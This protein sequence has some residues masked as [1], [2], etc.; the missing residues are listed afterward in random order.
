MK[1]VVTGANGF[2][3]SHVVRCLARAGHTVVPV[4][5]PDANTRFLNKRYGSPVS[6]AMNSL[7]DFRSVF[8]GADCVVHAAALAK[9]WGAWEEFNEANNL[10]AERVA[11]AAKQF[12]VRHLVHISTNA[13]LGEEDCS[14]A[15]AEDAPYNPRLPYFGEGIVRSA[16][17]FY[18]ETKTEGEKRVLA[19]AKEHQLDTTVVRPVW[20]FGPREFHSGPYEY[21][22][23]VRDLPVFPGC[24]S[25]LFHAVF[26][27][28]VARMV[29]VI[30]AKHPAGVRVYNCGAKRVLP[31]AEFFGMFSRAMGARPPMFIPKWSAYLF[32]TMIELTARVL[33]TQNPPP[34]TRARLYM[35]YAN[36]VYDVGK[37]ERELGFVADANYERAIRKTI[38][39]WKKNKFL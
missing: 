30:V 36:N 18:R 32:A 14:T 15:K 11:R 2:I 22:K 27:E 34:L 25:N 28:D 20:V 13:V 38:R 29:E 7:G 17:N 26:V 5:R 8:S 9:D 24:R 35:F 19:F 10:L 4:V 31:M 1:V 37:A 39:W 23:T 33:R 12:G 3:G 16:M 6:C 21:C